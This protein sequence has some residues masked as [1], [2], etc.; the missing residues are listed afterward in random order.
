MLLFGKQLKIGTRG[1][2]L[3]LW[4]AHFVKEKL[5]KLGFECE[6]VTIKTEGDRINKPLYEFGGKGLFI[7]EIELALLEK[8]VDV[9]VHSLKD[10]SV[11]ENEDF[12]FV[13]LERD[14]ERDV[15]VSLKGNVFEVEKGA[16]I[17][18]SSLRRRAELYRLRNDF[19]FVNLRG[20]LDTR[21][22]KLKNGE[23]D[24][25]VVSKAG[26][27]RLGIYDNTY[28]YDLES[29]VPSA[30]QGVIAI[31]FLKDCKFAKEIEKLEHK[32]TRVCVDAERSFVKQ[33]NASCNYPIGAYAFFSKNNDFCMDV[34]YGFVDDITKS[35]RY[36]FCS[37]SILH[38]LA[39]C[40]EEVEKGIKQ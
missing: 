33:L 10:M 34:M 13:V 18:T 2:K 17:G 14:Y 12:R 37:S 16:K 22:K 30:S 38:T 8:R 27:V 11:F 32:Q 6:I 24:A 36:S 1:S 3:A 26:L 23:F 9:A 20:N 4:Q 39:Q 40:L 29:V 28:M 35:I 5:E 25:I 15:F 21:L 31:E 19:E 7:K